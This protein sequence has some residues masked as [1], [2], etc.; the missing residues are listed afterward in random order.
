MTQEQAQKSAHLIKTIEAI[1]DDIEKLEDVLVKNMFEVES[2]I[3]INGRYAGLPVTFGGENKRKI[4][5]IAIQLLVEEKLDI[6][7]KISEL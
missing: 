6:E 3:E 5:E 4:L 7:A 2:D 1:N